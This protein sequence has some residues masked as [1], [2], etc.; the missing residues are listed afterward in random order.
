MQNT[1]TMP[2]VRERETLARRSAIMTVV[3]LAAIVA[4]L[5]LGFWSLI[6]F[7]SGLGFYASIAASAALSDPLR[8]HL[9][10]L[11]S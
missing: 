8:R 9:T 3:Y 2:S 7:G 5:A 4:T 10:A 1:L 11:L 6:S